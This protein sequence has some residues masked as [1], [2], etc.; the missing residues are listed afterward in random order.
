MQQIQFGS[1]FV[2]VSAGPPSGDAV[3]IYEDGT[4]TGLT[5]FPDDFGADLTDEAISCKLDDNHVILIARFN[6][7]FIQTVSSGE[8]KIMKSELLDGTLGLC[9]LSL[10]GN[11]C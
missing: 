1:L 4:I 2:L 10:Q 5:R 7:F 8:W 6:S 11:I 3:E 9:L